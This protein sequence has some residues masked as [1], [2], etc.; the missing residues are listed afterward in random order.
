[1]D[2]LRQT[3]QPSLPVIS[4]LPSLDRKHRT[5]QRPTVA[6]RREGNLRGIFKRHMETAEEQRGELIVV[7]WRF[8]PVF[9]S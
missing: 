9:P 3:R 8:T 1:M 6:L 5:R 4:S 7:M 2:L